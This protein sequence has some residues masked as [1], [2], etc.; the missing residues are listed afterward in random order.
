[1]AGSLVSSIVRK[2]GTYDQKVIDESIEKLSKKSAR[3]RGEVYELVKE[4]YVNFDACVTSTVSLEQ[5]V[6]EV[7]AEYQRISSVIERDLTS[8]MVQSGSK[9]EEVESKLEET[10]SR[11]VLVQQLV[12]VYQAIEQAKLEFQSGKFLS[13]AQHLS[14]AT[15]SLSEVAGR[16]C[17]A[18]VFHALKSEL[19]QTM[20]DL[21][22]RLQEKWR[23]FVC[24][25]PKVIP[26]EPSIKVLSGVELRVTA[27]STASHDQQ[28][29]EVVLAMKLLSSANVWGDRVKLFAQKLLQYVIKP[30]IAHPTLQMSQSTDRGGLLLRLSES[31]DAQETSIPQLYD[32]LV[33]V[34]TFARRVVTKDCEEEWMQALGKILLPELEELIIAHRLSTSIPRDPDE[35]AS[36]D[37]IREKTRTFEAALVKIGVRAEG[38]VASMSEYSDDVNV[39]FVSQKV[40]DMLAKARS[41]LMQPLHDTV[42]VSK[43]NPLTKLQDILPLPPSSSSD[44]PSEGLDELDIASLTFAFPKCAISRSVQEFVDHLYQT[45]EECA[46]SS[47]PVAATQF[48]NLA[49]NMVDLFCGVLFSHHH[50]AISDLPRVAALQHNNCAYLAHHLLTLGHQFHSR[51][52]PH[53]STAGTFVDQ[54]P[55]VRSLGEECLLAE[56]R[57]Q[58]SCLLDFLNSIGSFAGVSA[59]PRRSIVRQSLHGA[60]LHIGKLSK[61]YGEV[62]P[63]DVHR[64]SVGGLLSVLMA[65]MTRMVVSMEDI[66]AGDATELHAVLSGVMD[67]LPPMLGGEETSSDSPVASCKGWERVRVLAEVLNASLLEIVE[68]WDGGKGRLASEFS[69]SET[70]GLIKALFKN[71]ERRAAALNKI[72]TA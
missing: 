21:T 7:R 42:T 68:L 12:E 18:K 70:R 53:T 62:L 16:G 65:E 35:L 43:V 3:V 2:A 37:T 59:D 4:N 44:S 11:I 51:L 57:K 32:A 15:Q 19:A 22:L 61:V 1:M 56:L 36:Y 31:L 20:S 28:Y 46:L 55:L 9:R 30:L 13:A 39:H 27:H 5:Q 58:S 26:S 34:F 29:E 24:W 38:S 17:E 67:R 45:L 6:Q 10:Q 33:G 64:K 41:I 52:P 25:T 48:L 23:A 40:Q 71:T 63:V 49:R 47:G 66:A 54:V 69:V 50:R 60:T 72:T 14:A 8:K